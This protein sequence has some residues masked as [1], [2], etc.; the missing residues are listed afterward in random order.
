M[1]ST[2]PSTTASVDA[3][4]I[5]ATSPGPVSP[6]FDRLRRARHS[7]LLS[8]VVVNAALIALTTWR[9]P[10]FLRAQTFRVILDNMAPGALLI[11]PTVMLL[12]AGR[13]DLSMDGAAVLGGVSA[14]LV[15]A[16]SG[17]PPVVGL[18]VGLAVGVAVGVANGIAV[19]HLDMNPLITTLATW[20]IS[21]GI[22]TGLTKG[23]SP[24]RFRDGFEAIGR[25][26][27]FGLLPAVWY[28]LAVTVIAAIV[29]GM[30]R[31]GRHIRA[32]GGDREAARLNGVRTKRVGVWLYLLSGLAAAFVG[33]V[34][35]ARLGSASAS[36]FDGLTL[37]VIAAAVIGGA[38]LTGGRGSI[39]GGL[40]GLFLLKTLASATVAV[41]ISPFWQRAIT[42]AVLLAAVGSDAYSRWRA[43]RVANKWRADERRPAGPDS[44]KP[45]ANQLY[46]PVSERG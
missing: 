24:G 15:L 16:D 10:S 29:F 40:L 43:K 34:F 33:V 25:T 7:R 12:A 9:D 31:A 8:L 27:I 35:A 42:G 23:Q 44:T 20:W 36:A 11:A 19:E 26:R 18:V 13:F 1:T 39:I 45:P 22:A 37:E 41:G 32:T 2:A 5:P 21:I 6:V 30:M 38:A 17:A 3:S 28:A 46:Q 4:A 14:G